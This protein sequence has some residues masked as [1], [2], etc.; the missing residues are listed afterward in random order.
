MDLG[1][2]YGRIAYFARG[3]VYD[4]GAGPVASCREAEWVV[5]QL[6]RTSTAMCALAVALA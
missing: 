6:G 3:E 1:L 4:S 5:I 2:I